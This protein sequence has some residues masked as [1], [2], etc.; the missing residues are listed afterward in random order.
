MLV[1]PQAQRQALWT[2]N[3]QGEPGEE[4]QGTR[5]NDK[6]GGTMEDNK[7]GGTRKAD[8]VGGK[9]GLNRGW[10]VRGC[11]HCAADLSLL[12]RDLSPIC[13]LS[14]YRRNKCLMS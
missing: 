7:G 6:G 3:I 12:P 1:L 10:G 11:S 9:L 14:H 2:L 5:E 8:G 13:T 4:G